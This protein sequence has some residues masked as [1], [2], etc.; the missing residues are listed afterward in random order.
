MIEG[1][2]LP[3]LVSSRVMLRWMTP[4]DAEDIYEIFSDKEVMRY[5]SRG[6]LV[7]RDE[8]REMLVSIERCFRERALYQWGIARQPD[9]RIIGT[10]TLRHIDAAHLRAEVGY[11]LGRASWGQGLMNEALD[12]LLAFA[13]GVLALRRLE[14]DVD[15]RNLRSIRCLERLGFRREGHLRERWRVEGEVQ[16]S[17]LY[18][19]LRREWRERDP[20]PARPLPAR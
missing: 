11:A 20:A 15:P 18:G 13:F 7:T 1:D 10:C 4:A 6:P 19:L 12:R 5:W 14:A 3:T 16:D 2:L 8:A 9:D 17:L